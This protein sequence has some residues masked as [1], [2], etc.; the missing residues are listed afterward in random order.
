MEHNNEHTELI[1]EYLAGK[2]APDKAAELERRIAAS[3]DMKRELAELRDIYLGVAAYDNAVGDH[4]ESELLVVYCDNRSEL[5]DEIVA[6][7]DRHLSDCKQCRE[8]V[9][10]CGDRSVQPKRSNVEPKRGFFH[11]MLQTVL[12]PRPLVIRPV[13]LVAVLAVAAIPII[14]SVPQMFSPAD[15]VAVFDIEAPTRDIHAIN[16]VE[17]DRYQ[18]LISMRV[19][20][21]TIEGRNYELHLLD[22]AGSIVL[23]YNQPHLDEGNYFTLKVPVSYLNEGTYILRVVE[24]AEGDT[25]PEVFDYSFQVVFRN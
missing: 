22:P 1:A 10:L 21:P 16:R 17:I 23:T 14:L 7:I 19:S 13:A 6:E 5:E 4:I 11:A 25:L 12:S 8:E 24:S 3:P 20:P 18:Q 9:L 2:L 15:G